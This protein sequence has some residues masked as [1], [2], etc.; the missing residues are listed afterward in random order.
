VT[1][2]E[3]REELDMTGMTEITK[4]RELDARA[5]D[6]ID[7]RL[8]WYP[9]TEAVTVSVYDARHD[10]AFELVVD[11]DEALDAFHHPFAHACFRGISFD[12]PARAYD[13]EAIRT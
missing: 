6:G 3:R 2:K 4:A 8:L 7:V 9:A 5:G 11:P 13:A 1:P 12:A 10:H